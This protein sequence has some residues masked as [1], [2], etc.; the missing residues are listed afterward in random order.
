MPKNRIQYG[1]YSPWFFGPQAV[2]VCT[3]N[4]KQL[5]AWN[6]RKYR[7]EKNISQ[8]NLTEIPFNFGITGSFNCSNNNLNSLYG[9][10]KKVLGSF[11]CS[12]NNLKSLEYSPQSI[13]GSFYCIFNQ[14]F[15]VVPTFKK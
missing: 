5:I 10:P 1:D 12:H 8:E 4:A 9:S 7:V 6:L 2:C 3:M 11:Y 15:I 13:S 14:Y